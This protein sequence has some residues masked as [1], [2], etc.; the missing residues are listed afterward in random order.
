MTI[1]P[2]CHKQA[3]SLL[4][5]SFLGPALSAQCRTCGKRVSV[6]R[7]AT[8]GAAMPLLLS[9]VVAPFLAPQGWRWQFI[10]LSML[11]GFFVTI[12]LHSYLVPLVPRG[13]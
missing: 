10:A 3:M 12:A 6:S 5:K 7:A 11:A 13:A 2:Y 8:L 4:R 9:S 1:C